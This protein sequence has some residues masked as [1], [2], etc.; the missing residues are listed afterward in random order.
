M[1]STI[2]AVG[3]IATVFSIYRGVRGGI[4]TDDLLLVLAASL[5]LIW[6]SGDMAKRKARQKTEARAAGGQQAL[7]AEIGKIIGMHGCC[8][9]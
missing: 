8:R 7:G 5:A 6:L 4:P 3:V 1:H 9:T 2:R